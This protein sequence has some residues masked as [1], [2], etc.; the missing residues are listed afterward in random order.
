MNN[1]IFALDLDVQKYFYRIFALDL[2]ANRGF[3]GKSTR[4]ARVVTLVPRVNHVNNR[5]FAVDLDSQKYFYRIFALDLDANRV[6]EGPNP[7]FFQKHDFFS[8]TRLFKNT[9]F[10]FQKHVFF[11]KTRLFSKTWSFKNTSFQKPVFQ[12]HGFFV[13]KGTIL[14]GFLP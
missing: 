10:S 14:L 9:V 4:R 2:D 1:R 3:E 12:K 11:K 7:R 5:I 13:I 6:F 8:K